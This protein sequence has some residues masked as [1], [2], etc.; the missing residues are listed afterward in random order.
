[1]LS[2]FSVVHVCQKVWRLIHSWRNDNDNNKGKH[3][4][5]AFVAKDCRLYND[6]SA[7]QESA[8]ATDALRQAD[9]A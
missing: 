4:Q 5:I 3:I 8:E 2:Q 7:N 9:L 6:V 1:M